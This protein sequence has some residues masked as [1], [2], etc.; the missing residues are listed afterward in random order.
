MDLQ[1]LK[2]TINNGESEKVEFKTSFNDTVIETQHGV[3]KP[4]F[5]EWTQGFRVILFKEKVT[6]LENDLE[7]DL[8]EILSEREIE[9]LKEIK[10]NHKIT[11]SRL[12]EI[13][14]ISPKNIRVYIKKLKDKGFLE[15]IGPVNGGYWSINDLKNE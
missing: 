12:S 13:I 9:I 11:Q 1:E 5:E 6:D 3:K 7:N 10:Q 8:K 15:R 4:L 14:G 2:S